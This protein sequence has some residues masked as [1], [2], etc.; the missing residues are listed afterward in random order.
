MKRFKISLI[1]AMFFITGI[2]VGTFAV[3]LISAEKCYDMVNPLVRQTE[4][5]RIKVFAVSF[6]HSI[7]P[8]AFMWLSGFTVISFYYCGAALLYKGCVFGMVSGGIIR[9]YGVLKGIILI[10]SGIFPHNII[11][12]PL[13]IYA[14]SVAFIYSKNKKRIR[15]KEYLFV[16]CILIVGSLITSFCD[17]AI[18]YDLL[19]RGIKSVT[20]G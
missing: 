13:L 2:L 6:A 10:L 4:L 5:N 3:G 12:I 17:S 18:T 19:N 9:V 11:Y 20:N 16:M 1:Y 7:K 8:L 14:A 15:I